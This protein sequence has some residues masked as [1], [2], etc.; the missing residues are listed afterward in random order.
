[1]AIGNKSALYKI[2]L[3]EILSPQTTKPSNWRADR[4]CLVTIEVT[5]LFSEPPCPAKQV[6]VG[7][8]PNS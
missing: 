1:M 7:V 3:S 2:Q 6:G 5:L 8:S 4:Y